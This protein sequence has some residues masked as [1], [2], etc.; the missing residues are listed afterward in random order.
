MMR[1]SKYPDYCAQKIPKQTK[2]DLRLILWERVTQVHQQH[3]PP[4]PDCDIGLSVFVSHTHT[5]THTHTHNELHSLVYFKLITKPLAQI[6]ESMISNP[7]ALLSKHPSIKRPQLWEQGEMEG[8]QV[9]NKKSKRKRYL[10]QCRRPERSAERPCHTQG[11]P[12]GSPSSANRTQ[13][14][15]Q[16][17]PHHLSSSP[18]N[19]AKQRSSNLF[20]QQVHFQRECKKRHHESLLLCCSQCKHTRYY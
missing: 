2:C 11:F 18:S 17:R 6:S 16:Q 19:S 1:I 20:T 14:S 12:G 7:D 5:H 9:Q 13:H 15:S 3:N 10:E 4:R 8:R